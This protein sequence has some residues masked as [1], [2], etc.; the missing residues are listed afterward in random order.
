M[1]KKLIIFGNSLMSEIVY[2]YFKN[3]SEYSNSEIL[4]S[5]DKKFLINKSKFNCE[6]IDTKKLLKL[7]KKDFDIF[8]AIG[9]SK[10][11]TIREKFYK[12]F[13]KKNFNLIN[14]IHPDA[15][16]YCKKIGINNFIMDNVSINP[17]TY[18][19][20]NNIIWSSTTIGH[21][22]K[23]KS[24]NFFSGNTTISGN[25]EIMNN[26][27]FGVN[28]CTKDNI[29]IANY[30]FID[31]GEYVFNSIKNFTFYNEIHNKNNKIKTKDLFLD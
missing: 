29:K 25:S 14:F 6:V 13:L 19:G 1:K 15:K 2:Y 23:I 22:N 11:N 7:Q 18:I 8:I 16:V 10:L 31:A 5:C 26:C 12:F 9:Y 21:H 20:D 4:F 3:F 28:S 30:C 24:N 17:Y 27:F